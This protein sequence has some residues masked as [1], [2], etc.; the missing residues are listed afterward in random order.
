MAD[1]KGRAR[2]GKSCITLHEEG[3]TVVAIYMPGEACKALKARDIQH[4]IREA[5]YA[6]LRLLDEGIRNL[7]SAQ[8]D[9]REAVE[10]PVA[11][12]IDGTVSVSVAR[13]KMRAEMT[14][15][16]P[17]GGR[18]VS[19]ED[20]MRALQ[21]QGV[22]FGIRQEVIDQALADG[23]ARAVVVAEGVAAEDG[24]DSRF[25]V[26]YQEDH[27][28]KPR[29][30]SDGRADMRELGHFLVVRKGD[31]LMRRL[32]PTP[33]TS[34]HNVLGETLPAVPGRERPFA[35]GLNGAEID[36]HNANLLVASHGGQPQAVECGVTVNPVLLVPTVDIKTGNVHFEGT[37]KVSGN[38]VAG[39]TVTATEDVFVSGTVEGGS[40]IAGRNIS[41]GQG[42]IGRIDLAEQDGA[43]AALRTHIACGGD[44]EARFIEHARVEAEGNVHVTNQVL[45]SEVMA[46]GQLQVGSDRSRKGHILGGIARAG[47]LIRARVVGSPAEV[48]TLLEVGSPPRLHEQ[49]G[50]MRENLLRLMDEKKK[51]IRLVQHLQQDGRE[52][53]RE[54]LTRIKAR[55][56]G[57][58]EELK[59]LARLY[60]EMQSEE[61]CLLEA[62]VVV[63]KKIHHG[64]H[65]LI[66]GHPYRIEHEMPGGTFLLRD[67][68]VEYTA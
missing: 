45:H 47:S 39:T 31:P 29:L 14:V 36:P 1:E 8:L 57:V 46:G 58:H 33:G 41:V 28:D 6:D 3:N 62:S 44:L 59:T 56:T 27:E 26:L 5:G 54:R 48:H 30:D 10:T 64:V 12:R 17:E 65:L 52:D 38:V 23:H 15:T 9:A 40:L 24:E 68:E 16:P 20:V 32:P 51:L 34:G 22:V 25:K 19:G 49:T 4:M 50:E 60:Q 21:E 43:P 55:L 42:I 11:E 66:C 63:E 53:Q 37:V 67:G 7:E 2:T 61:Q 13:D 18:P 35:T